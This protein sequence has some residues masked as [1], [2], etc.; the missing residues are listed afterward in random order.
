MTIA[1][2]AACGVLTPALAER[3][4]AALTPVC[5]EHGVS[6]AELR[7]RGRRAHLVSARRDAMHAAFAVRPPGRDRPTYAEVAAYFRRDHTTVLYYLGMLGRQR[8]LPPE[9]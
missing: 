9:V 6:L 3:F 8:P 4:D 5:T 1:S 7:G 2:T